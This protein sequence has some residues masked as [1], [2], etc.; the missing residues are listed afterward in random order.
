MSPRAAC[1]LEALGFPEV[2]DYAAGKADWFAFGYP[3][4]GAIDTTRRIG[5][6]LRNDFCRARLTDRLSDVCRE[7]DEAES[8]M[9]AVTAEDGCLLGVI[10]G[11]KLRQ[12]ADLTAEEAMRP[13]PST[14]R[15]GKTIQEMLEFMQTRNVTKS[16]VT[17]SSG[18]LLGIVARSDLERASVEQPPDGIG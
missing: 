13:G 15:P 1:R 5:S 6:L 14:F 4:E 8:D 17:N 18:I 2:Y 9:C 16:L 10:R 7:C 12:D 11:S 3:A